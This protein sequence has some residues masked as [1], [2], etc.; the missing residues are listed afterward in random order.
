VVGRRAA[1][2]LLAAIAAVLASSAPRTVA[3]DA[4]EPHGAAGDAAEGRAAKEFEAELQ[5][6]AAVPDAESVAELVRAVPRGD[7]R[8]ARRLT[9][10]LRAR[11]GYACARGL[12]AL[13]AWEDARVRET[14]LRAIAQN[15]LRV[16]ESMEAVRAARRDDDPAVRD[17]AYAAL[18]VVGDGTD[19]PSLIDSL[20]DNDPDG[21]RGAFDALT[22]ISNVH[23]AYRDYLW[24]HWWKESQATFPARLKAALDAVESR[25]RL[26]NV[27]D[28]RGVIRRT[29]W[30]DLPQV[31]AR[32]VRWLG[33]GGP[34]LRTDAFRFCTDLRLGDLADTVRAAQHAEYDESV[35]PVALECATRLGVPIAAPAASPARASR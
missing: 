2:V 28:A 31:S 24:R 26:G 27:D 19:V 17:A 34:E 18:A 4:A 12:R 8:F 29:A 11:G 32:L 33:A 5:R 15:G 21:L 9:A 13:V 6:L 30:I 22:G 14:A 23:F 3:D 1:V 7:P 35:R 10:E 16:A 20:R 25:G